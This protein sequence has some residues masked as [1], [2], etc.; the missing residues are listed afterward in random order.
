MFS[1]VFS[2]SPR[3]QSLGLHVKGVKTQSV[4]NSAASHPREAGGAAHS[5][6]CLCVILDLKVR[7]GIFHLFLT[8][9]LSLRVTCD[10]EGRDQRCSMS[11]LRSI[12]C[13]SMTRQAR[14][15]SV[16]GSKDRQHIN[17]ESLTECVEGLVRLDYRD[18]LKH[19]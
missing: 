4:P 6:V 1:A 3:D 16:G 15:Q 11:Y 19:M 10:H 7:E 14:A 2:L 12:R 9:C 18:T 8:H 17:T 5:I 13:N